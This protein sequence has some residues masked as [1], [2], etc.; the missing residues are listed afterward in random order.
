MAS[1]LTISW[2]DITR[3][4]L[5]AFLSLVTFHLFKSNQKPWSAQIIC[6]KCLLQ[7]FERERS[8]LR[9]CFRSWN[10]NVCDF[11]RLVQKS[12]NYE[13]KSWISRKIFHGWISRKI[14]NLQIYVF[15]NFSFGICLNLNFE[16]SFFN[17]FNYRCRKER[18]KKTVF[19][20]LS[21]N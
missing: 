13:L 11:K 19:V 10:S 17:R 15:T 21:R 16:F 2:L 4:K 5:F 1:K 12:S 7:I 9:K 8:S 3:L 14:F 20:A 6:S 18:S